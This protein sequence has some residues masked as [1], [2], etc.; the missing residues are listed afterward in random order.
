MVGWRGGWVW[1]VN[2]R[3]LGSAGSGKEEKGKLGLYY[4]S[5]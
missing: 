1:G 5:R 4:S 3:S 2:D